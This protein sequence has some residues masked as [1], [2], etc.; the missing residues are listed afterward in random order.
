[1]DTNN[2]FLLIALVAS[3]IFILQFVISIFVGDLDVDVDGDGGADFDMGSLFSF[4]G[5]VHFLIGFGWTK[6]LFAGNTWTS[7]ALAIIVGMGFMVALFYTYMLAYRL[8]N[9]RRPER[10][11]SIVGRC[12]RIYINLGEGRY[13]IF[14]DRDGSLRE[15]DVVSASGRT[16]YLTD[17]VVTVTD[18]KDNIFYIE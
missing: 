16:D 8:Q 5:L 10:S 17:Q 12:G 14:V 13:T 3:G 9:L 15:L 1:M 18:F 2:L 11:E 4:K 7:Y 6:V